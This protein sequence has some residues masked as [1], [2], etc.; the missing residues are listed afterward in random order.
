M[1]LVTQWTD[2]RINKD[3]VIMKNSTDRYSKDE[4]NCIWK[5]HVVMFLLHDGRIYPEEVIPVK[6]MAS[7][8]DNHVRVTH[9]SYYIL[10]VMCRMNFQSFPFDTQTC[11]LTFTRCEYSVI[12]MIHTAIDFLFLSIQLSIRIIR[13]NGKKWFRSFG[14]ICKFPCSH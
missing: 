7:I 5:P 9:S 8:L 13:S 4:L 10:T 3:W 1:L 11:R 12:I 6:F 14:R 2:D